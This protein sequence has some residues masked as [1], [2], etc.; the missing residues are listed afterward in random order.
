MVLFQPC[1]YRNNIARSEALLHPQT[2]HVDTLIKNRCRARRR[3]F[4]VRPVAHKP[5]KS[6]PQSLRFRGRVAAKR[7]PVAMERVMHS[8]LWMHL[9]IQSHRWTAAF[10]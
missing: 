9:V 6:S 7:S 3:A 4:A 10:V 5:T 8:F 1:L 2:S